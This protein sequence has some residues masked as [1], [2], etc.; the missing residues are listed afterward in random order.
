MVEAMLAK[1]EYILIISVS[2]ILR[3]GTILSQYIMVQMFDRH[4]CPSKS[5]YI[6]LKWHTST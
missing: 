2:C 3:K 1:G 4:S 5:T 6:M